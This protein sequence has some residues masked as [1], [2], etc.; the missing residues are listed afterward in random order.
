MNG[1]RLGQERL[2]PRDLNLAATVVMVESTTRDA[3]T[4]ARLPAGSPDERARKAED[5]SV[6]K[7]RFSLVLSMMPVIFKGEERDPHLGIPALRE[8]SVLLRSLQR[9]RTRIH[10]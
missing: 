2:P 9:S 5:Q 6:E 1:R 3:S 10:Q 7:D 4:R 8:I